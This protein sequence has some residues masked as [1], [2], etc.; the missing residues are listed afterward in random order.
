MPL[1]AAPLVCLCGAAGLTV[2][3]GWVWLLAPI[4]L[5]THLVIAALLAGY[6]FWQRPQPVMALP[7]WKNP[8]VG[9]LAV[10]LLFLAIWL[11]SSQLPRLAD[12]GGYHAPMIEWIHEYAVVPGLANLNYRFGFNNSWFLLTAFFRFQLSPDVPWHGLNGWLMVMLGWF[13]LTEWHRWYQSG[14]H[15]LSAWLGGWLAVGLLLIFHWTLSSPSPDLPTHAYVVLCFWA[16]LRRTEPDQ[17]QYTVGWTWLV[18]LFSL[19]ALTTKLSAVTVLLLPAISILQTLYQRDW[20]NGLRLIIT[21]G[22]VTGSWWVGNVLLSGY[23]A[24]PSLSPLVD[25][26]SVDWKV[27]RGVIA[28]GLKNLQEGTRGDNGPVF[29]LGWIPYWFKTRP[30][31]EQA[32]Y[33]ALLAAPFVVIGRRKSMFTSLSGYGMAQVTAWLGVVFWFLLAP[34][35][36]FGAGNI[37]LALGLCYG[38]VLC[39]ATVGRGRAHWVGFSVAGLIGLAFVVAAIRRESV[40]WLL[41]VGYPDSPLGTYKADDRLIQYPADEQRVANG[42]RGYWG[43]CYDAALPCTPYPMPGLHWRGQNMQDGFRTDSTNQQ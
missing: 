19:L 36:R 41:P 21:I 6:G 14:K 5:A 33:A 11:R 24:Y 25:W 28:V 29:S 35:L 13:S 20:R 4:N 42:I 27:P 23:I 39:R 15:L 12:T 3:L 26:F 38:P 37:L 30:L 34:E 16:W 2:G 43:N 1:L 32:L 8:G 18:L 22:I 10:G 17:R 40:D 7:R 31:F 9:W